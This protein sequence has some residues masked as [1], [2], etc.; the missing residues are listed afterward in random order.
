MR[1]L[2]LVTF[3]FALGSCD[4]TRV[5]PNGCFSDED[6]SVAAGSVAPAAAYRCQTET[7]ECFCRTDEAC[8][9]GQLCNA[10][11]FCQKISGCEKNSDCDPSTFCDTTT[12][13]CLPVGRCSFD[14]QCPLGNV[15]DT[16]RSVCV[17]GCRSNGDCPGS[18]C[19]CGEVPCNCTGTTPA[20]LQKC[21]VGV[22]DPN[23]C[24]DNT[25]CKFGEL[26]GSIPD[27]GT[28]RNQCY[29]DFDVDRRP[30]CTNCSGGAGVQSCGTGANYCLIDTANPG[31]FF[32]GAD[33][34][35][36]Q[37]C[38]RGYDC[39]DVIVVYTQWACT[40]G[41]PACHANDSLICTKDE[42]C[43][44]GG[45]CVIPAGQTAGTCA[46]RCAVG[47]GQ[48]NGFCTCLQDSDCA[49]ESCSMGECSISRKKCVNTTDCRQPRCVDFGG[50]GGCLIGQNCAPADG[51][52][53]V[54]V[55][56]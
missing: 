28:T 45:T 44:F 41:N 1:P 50:V 27:A 55:A 38:P 17:P 39:S 47:E 11:G 32:C 53:C 4:R 26:C 7:G 24:S 33:C 14:L 52:S 30:Y 36:G 8:P 22:C 2:Y 21:T 46:G 16:S 13:T 54:Q 3:V 25:F 20:D 37:S 35:E 23:F 34:S 6:C 43:P 51:L 56:Q 31:N 5:N 40:R 10:V 49:Q 9:P 18:S 29:S 15:C 12:G 48:A 42:E 19:R